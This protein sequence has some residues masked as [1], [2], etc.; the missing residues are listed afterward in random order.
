MERKQALPGKVD[1][2]AV[3]ALAMGS[4]IQWCVTINYR[5]VR[6][7]RETR[8]QLCQS[9]AASSLYEGSS[10]VVNVYRNRV[11]QELKTVLTSPPISIP[12]CWP[13]TEIRQIR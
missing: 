13:L 1:L 6:R 7:S 9:T 5:S 3:S 12:D 8:N 10:S 4:E 11:G 2:I